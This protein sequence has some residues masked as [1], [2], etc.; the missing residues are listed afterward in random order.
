MMSG[1]SATVLFLF[2]VISS[3]SCTVRVLSR[4]CWYESPLISVSL[5]TSSDGISE[6]VDSYGFN[7][8]SRKTSQ[9]KV[10]TQ[11]APWSHPPVCTEVLQGLRSKL[12]VYTN[13]AFSNGR[14]ISI[15]TT[16]KVAQEFASLPPFQNAT[17]MDKINV[18]SGAWYTQELPGKGVGMLARKTLKFGDGVTA[19][20]P[21]LLAYLEGELPTLQRE[22]YFRIAVSQLPDATRDAFLQLTTVYGDERI[23]VQDI[24]KANTFQL[25]VGGQNHLAVFPET[26]R[27]N[28]ACAPNAQYHLNPKLL[29]HYVRA[30]RPIALGEEITISYT[31]PL[32][33]TEMRQQHLQSGFHFTCTCP[34]CTSKG[35]DATLSKMFAMQASLNDWSVTSDGTPKLAEELLQLYRQEGLEGF[36]DVPYG[37]AALA[38]NAVGNSKKAVTYAE[39][40]EEAIL[41]KDGVWSPNLRIWEEVMGNAKGHWSYKRRT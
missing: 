11:Y 7:A 21:A 31:S 17:A 40:A 22:K 24:V 37:F 25:E 23:R 15:F 20:T 18:F 39:K 30:T 28:H 33:P 14:G 19:H 16:P 8:L 13:A 10:G 4:Q 41:M 29:T 36:M 35:T 38:Y 6:L 3:A 5:S 1:V 2:F 27:L 9:T 32:E 12:C 34:R 26:S